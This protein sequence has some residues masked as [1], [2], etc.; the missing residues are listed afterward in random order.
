[1]YLEVTAQ[2]WEDMESKLNCSNNKFS[3]RSYLLKSIRY[4]LK[5]MIDV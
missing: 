4:L 5:I 2:S 1:M 3:F